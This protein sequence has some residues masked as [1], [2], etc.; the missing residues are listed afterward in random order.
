MVSKKGVRSPTSHRTPA[1][2]T[3]HGRTYQARPE[4]IKRRGARVQA[5]RDAGDKKG[6]GKDR[7]HAKP[8][9]RGGSLKGKT[10][11]QSPASNRGH[12][13]GKNGSKP[14]AKTL[15]MKRIRGKK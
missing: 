6:D 14:D 1:Q 10:S 13:M 12:G 8:L 3:E 11:L 7:A 15:A 5:G 9:A 2:I 4:V